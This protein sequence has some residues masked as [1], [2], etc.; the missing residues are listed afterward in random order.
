VISSHSATALAAPKLCSGGERS[1]AFLIGD[2]PAQSPP[3]AVARRFESRPEPRKVL[4]QPWRFWVDLVTDRKR[5]EGGVEP[6]RI[7]L[8]DLRRERFPEISERHA[9]RELDGSGA[10]ARCASLRVFSS[11]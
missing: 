3:A 4:A 10:R 2:V 11:A 9:L 5:L 8:L 7:E 1:Q 6:A